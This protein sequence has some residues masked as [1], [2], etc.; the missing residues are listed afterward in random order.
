[1]FGPLPFSVYFEELVRMKVMF[2][3][4]VPTAQGDPRF[5][6]SSELFRVKVVN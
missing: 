5:C 6:G 4:L 2:F 3:G 1:M